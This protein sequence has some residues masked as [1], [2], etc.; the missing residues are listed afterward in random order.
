[1]CKKAFRIFS[2]KGVSIP[3][4]TQ[5]MESVGLPLVYRGLVPDALI[6]YGIR[7]LLSGMVST[8]SV[9]PSARLAAKQAYV[10]DLKQRGLAE[11][12]VDANEQHYEVPAPFYEFV[13]GKH[14]KYSCG[15]WP[16]D[17]RGECTL[18]ESE[19]AALAL[20]CERAGLVN[21]AGLRVL[22]MGCGWGSFSL[23]AAA[24]FPL[25]TFT[26]V[27]NSNSQ[28]EYIMGQ[29][30]ARGLANLTIV[31]C[32]INAFEGAGREYDRVVSIEMM[33]HVKNYQL[34][35]RRVAS[36]MRP[37]GKMFVHIFTHT[38][39]PFHYVSLG[40]VFFVA[41]DALTAHIT[42]PILFVANF[43][44]PPPP[45]THAPATDRWVDGKDLFQWRPNALG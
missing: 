6:R 42:P 16:E 8:Q 21:E 24:R 27:S 2:K 14:K 32:D 17:G 11:H 41:W 4:P 30:A 44:L 5:D 22:D 25:V 20:V 35:L 26:G 38:H 3:S 34:L 23:Y 18:D 36:W 13:M 43:L 15:L 19:A 10:A 33:E 9:A 12:T 28:R 45:S 40:G 31:T 1:V 37:G 39:T 29:A 7:S